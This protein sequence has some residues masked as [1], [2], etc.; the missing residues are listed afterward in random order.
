MRLGFET[1]TELISKDAS[2]SL[3]Y[4]SHLLVKKNW[5]CDIMVWRDINLVYIVALM[6]IRH[7]M[8]AIWASLCSVEISRG[9]ATAS[10]YNISNTI[11]ILKGV[12][13]RP[14][15]VYRS[16]SVSVVIKNELK[17]PWIANTQKYSEC[18]AATWSC[19][20]K[21]VHVKESSSVQW[22]LRA[23]H[24]RMAPFSYFS[25]LLISLWFCYLLK[26]LLKHHNILNTAK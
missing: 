11:N 13:N 19:A 1:F 5:Y 26:I 25:W 6:C 10:S 18:E 16:S 9:R 4:P 7:E 21:Q 23:K 3:W 8:T 17:V 12:C 20:E 22:A 14:T 15:W 2:I 24:W